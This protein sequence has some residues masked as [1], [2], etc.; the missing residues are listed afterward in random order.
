MI[1]DCLVCYWRSCYGTCPTQ[2]NTIHSLA[3]SVSWVNWNLWART[4]PDAVSLSDQV[5]RCTT[6]SA[7]CGAL[8]HAWGECCTK[9]TSHCFF[10]SW[11]FSVDPILSILS[12][13][14][15]AIQQWQRE[16]CSLTSAVNLLS[17]CVIEARFSTTPLQFMMFKQSIDPSLI[18]VLNG[19]MIKQM[20]FF[21]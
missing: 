18:K 7:P 21:A 9:I 6:L 16:H 10:I 15:T 4:V 3:A 20:G 5:Q 8:L 12:T 14:M 19:V 2:Q 17:L 1:L 11:H 13:H